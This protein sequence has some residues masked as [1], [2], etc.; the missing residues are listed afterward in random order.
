[1]KKTVWA[2]IAVLA[3]AALIPL[4]AYG[5]QETRQQPQE[6]GR[7]RGFGPG[8]GGP[9][10]PGAMRVLQRLDLTETQREQV[11][12]ILDERRD[13]RPAHMMQLQQQLQAAIFADTVDL[14]KIEALK[15]QIASAEAALLSARIDT[16]T[17]IAQLLTPEQRAK[18][19]EL[20]ANRPGPAR[21]RRG[22]F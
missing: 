12:A 15:G 1:M 5:T 14:A 3:M 8:P 4:A 6:Q 7:G 16:E 11:K 20:V 19:R 13:E 18:A 17:R 22:G 10:G 21:G 2:A 9:G